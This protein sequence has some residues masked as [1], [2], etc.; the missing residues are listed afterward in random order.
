LIVLTQDGRVWRRLSEDGDTIEHEYIVE[1]SGDIAPWGLHRLS[2]GLSYQLREL[3][4]CKVSWQ[5]E[6]RLR[7]AIKGAQGG[8]L[9]DMCRQ[10][11]LEVIAIRRI[12]IGR[13]PLG[14]MPEGVWRYLPAGERF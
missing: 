14:K 3:P 12:R 1:V 8:Q 11:G 6:A 2:H 5:S 13:I 4:P 7:F 9:R 10:V